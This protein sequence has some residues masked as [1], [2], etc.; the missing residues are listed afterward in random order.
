MTAIP[1]KYRRDL[2]E[3]VARQAPTSVVKRACLNGN[4]EILGG[5][6]H[7]LPPSGLPGWIV[8]LVT[9]NRHEILVGVVCNEHA[10]QYEVRVIDMVPWVQWMG[11]PGL[12]EYWVY[13][14]D[15]PQHYADLHRIAMDNEQAQ[16]PYGPP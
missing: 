4:V 9:V 15:H 2:I 1:I 12:H 6:T 11:D 8:R 14:G 10:H 3:L 5:F 13:N 7:V 16:V